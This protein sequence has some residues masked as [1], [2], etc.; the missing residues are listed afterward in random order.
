MP[1][2]YTP[3]TQSKEL[4]EEYRKFLSVQEDF[5][6][7]LL[8]Q[9]EALNKRLTTLEY[10]HAEQ[11][12]RKDK[13]RGWEYEPDYYDDDCCSKVDSLER[14]YAEERRGS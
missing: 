9:I 5:L 3:K 13:S 14:E 2:N 8:D 6:G 10:L 7:C 1:K 4:T 11:E 12:N